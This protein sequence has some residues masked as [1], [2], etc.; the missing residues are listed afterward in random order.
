MTEGR[1]KG[2]H[3]S[4]VYLF[5]EPAEDA[6]PLIDDSSKQK[7]RDEIARF[8]SA[9]IGAEVGFGAISYR[10]WLD[11]WPESD[12]ELVATVTKF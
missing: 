9:V 6:S 10:E 1:R 3:P 2:K 4:L 12:Q 7:H 8:S 5:A 11:S